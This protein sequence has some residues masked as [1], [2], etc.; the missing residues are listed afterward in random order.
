MEKQI[1]EFLKRAKPSASGG[2]ESIIAS[3]DLFRDGWLDSL[4]NLELLAYLEKSTG[5]RIPMLKVTRKNFQTVA[6]I[7]ALVQNAKQ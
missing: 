4:S 1:A 2:V 7:A 6:S 3:R 5:A